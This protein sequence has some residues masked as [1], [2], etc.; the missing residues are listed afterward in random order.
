[1]VTAN[2]PFSF[3]PPGDAGPASA[4]SAE[5]RAADAEVAMSSSDGSARSC[6]LTRYLTAAAAPLTSSPCTATTKRRT[7]A[8]SAASG[9]T[10]WPRRMKLPTRRDAAESLCASAAS[11][12]PA[13]DGHTAS[14]GVPSCAPPP[15]SAC[16]SSRHDVASTTVASVVPGCSSTSTVAAA[17]SFGGSSSTSTSRTRAAS[18]TGISRKWSA[19]PPCGATPLTAVSMSSCDA[20]ARPLCSTLALA[21]SSSSSVGQSIVGAGQKQVCSPLGPHGRA[22][23]ET[24]ET[25]MPIRSS[26]GARPEVNSTRTGSPDW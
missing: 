14:S 21:R 7:P 19:I 20:L 15:L 9:E 5:A 16:S 13:D 1:M 8:A 24:Y 6:Q 12:P 11:R 17:P 26:I 2:A 23:R 10:Q 4:P 18:A 22:V 25:A 3:C